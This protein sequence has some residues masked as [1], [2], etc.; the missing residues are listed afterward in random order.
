M[1]ALDDEALAGYPCQVAAKVPFEDGEDHTSLVD[2][3]RV[4]EQGSPYIAYAMAAGTQPRLGTGCC[5][6][7]G[8]GVGVGVCVSVSVCLCEPVAT[9][10][11]KTFHS[12]SNTLTSRAFLAAD[13]AIRDSWMDFLGDRLDKTRVVRAIGGVRKHDVRL[14]T[15]HFVTAGSS[16]RVVDWR[17]SRVGRTSCGTCQRREGSHAC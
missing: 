13:E 10:A 11:R 15:V 4:R 14:M 1:Q 7:V 12:D 9:L 3:T 6:I 5:A 2:R 16:N 17:V 8:V